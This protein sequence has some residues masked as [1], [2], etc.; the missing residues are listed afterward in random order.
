[1][2]E[3]FTFKH[4]GESESY[5]DEVYL[6]YDRKGNIIGTVNGKLTGIGT[7][8]LELDKRGVTFVWPETDGSCSYR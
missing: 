7:V 6:I 4:N 3:Y 1:M 5:K 2:I 8:I